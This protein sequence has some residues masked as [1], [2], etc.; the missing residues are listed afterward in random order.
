MVAPAQF[1]VRSQRHLVAAGA[2]A[3]P[4]WEHVGAERS[5]DA[6]GSRG[7]SSNPGTGMEASPRYHALHLP[8]GVVDRADVY[9]WDKSALRFAFIFSRRFTK[10][11]LLTSSSSVLS[12]AQRSWKQRGKAALRNLLPP[13]VKGLPRFHPTAKDSRR[14]DTLSSL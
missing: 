14:L 4:A 1:G 5:L 6:L 13:N 9:C 7:H 3:G 2:V 11:P 10:W 12:N 8:T